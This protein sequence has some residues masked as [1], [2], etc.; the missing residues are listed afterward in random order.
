MK[1]SKNFRS[2]IFILIFLPII[3]F[4]GI[5]V[6]GQNKLKNHYL[7]AH[8]PQGLREIFHYTGDSVSFLSAHRGGAARNFP[9]NC[10][11]TF[12]HTLEHTYA[13]M[14]MD[15]RFTR[16]NVMVVIHDPTLDR[17]TTGHGRVADFTYNE[18]K[19][20][21]LK[22]S[23]GNIT[24]YE[25][26]TLREMLE[27]AKG[28]TILILDKKDVPIEFR[29]K[30]V[31]DC[32]AEACAIVMAYSFEEAKLAYSLNKDIL[33]QIFINSPEKVLEFDLTGVPWTSILVS[34]G[35]YTPDEPAVIEMIH[36]RGALCKMGTVR[37]LDL[38]Y[39]K[40]KVIHIEELYKE[41]NALFRKGADFLET[42]IPVPVS[43]IIANRL[44]SE[45]FRLKF[46]K[47]Q[48]GDL[49]QGVK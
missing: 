40:G 27:W 9:E 49:F 1:N 41:Y 6:S 35:P 24:D 13:I 48:S 45:T 25:I 36:K 43:R 11:A 14:E 44:S 29:I 3:L 38:E 19:A 21:K 10:T 16:D 39:F 4:F 37:N 17:T 28:K 20:L 34:L 31:E 8:T 47:Q 30:M 5:D 46:L 12:E 18:L 42:D 2:V 7:N 26:Q 23:E 33:I 15:P 22:D 32:K